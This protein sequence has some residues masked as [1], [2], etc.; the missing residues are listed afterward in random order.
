MAEQ[1]GL[2]VALGQFPSG[3]GSVEACLVNR[4][5]KVVVVAGQPLELLSHRGVRVAGETVPIDLGGAAGVVPCHRLAVMAW[6]RWWLELGAFLR[7]RWR[8]VHRQ[9]FDCV[10]ERI[11]RTDELG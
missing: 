8:V 7:L 1:L 5:G 10:G 9:D 4:V 2:V 3:L 6:P 11:R